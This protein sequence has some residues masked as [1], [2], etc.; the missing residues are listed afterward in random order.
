MKATQTLQRY[1][2]V[3]NA[4]WECA[5]TAAAGHDLHLN[6]HTQVQEVN[7]GQYR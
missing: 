6:H 5:G 3:L 4:F 1:Q 7:I 2:G